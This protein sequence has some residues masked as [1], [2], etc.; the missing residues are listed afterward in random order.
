MDNLRDEELETLEADLHEKLD[1]PDGDSEEEQ[2]E[3]RKRSLE[4]LTEIL[5]EIKYRKRMKSMFLLIASWTFTYII[6]LR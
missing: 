5:A 2:V 3:S 4:T 1:H 6:A